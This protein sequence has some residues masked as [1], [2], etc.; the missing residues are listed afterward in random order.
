MGG[1]LNPLADDREVARD[2]RVRQD[3]ATPGSSGSIIARRPP[4]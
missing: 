4:A 3:L 1:E 2:A